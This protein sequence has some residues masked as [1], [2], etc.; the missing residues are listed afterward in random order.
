MG[1]N[2]RPAKRLQ[3][4]RRNRII[5]GVCGGIA[6]YFDWSP[7]TVRLVFIAS[8]ILPGTQVVIYLLLWILMP[9]APRY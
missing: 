5:A 4:S 7:S 1:G 6:E 2:D 3:R 8:L 9:N